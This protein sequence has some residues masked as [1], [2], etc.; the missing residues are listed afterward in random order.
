MGALLELWRD[1]RCSCRVQTK[2]SWNLLSCLKG[3]KD[4]VAWLRREGGIP[5][6]TPQMKK[7]ARFEWRISWFFSSDSGIPLELR[8]GPQGPTHGASGRSSLHE[9]REGPLCNLQLL[10]GLMSYLELRQ[11]PRGSSPGLTWILGSS[12]VHFGVREGLVSCGAMQIRSLKPKNQCQASCQ[13]G[14]RDCWLSLEA[15]QSCHICRR[16]LSLSSG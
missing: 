2:M 5:H 6:K 7:S 11:E 3:F 13:V 12:G 16:V 8:W 1:P 15:S 14:P 9:S 4:P 10:P